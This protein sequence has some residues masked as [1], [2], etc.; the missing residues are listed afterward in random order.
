M[1]LTLTASCRVTTGLEVI[2]LDNNTEYK[3]QD[4][5]GQPQKR[6]DAAATSFA[7]PKAAR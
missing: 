1:F 4:A 6:I 7:L 2:A 5:L 3:C